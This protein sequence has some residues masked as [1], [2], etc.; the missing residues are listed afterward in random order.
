MSYLGTFWGD[1]GAYWTYPGGAWSR[2][3][4]AEKAKCKRRQEVKKQHLPNMTTG[5]GK[6]S[7]QALHSGRA[8]KRREVEKSTYPTCLPNRVHGRVMLASR[9]AQGEGKKRRKSAYPTWVP[10]RVHCHVRWSCPTPCQKKN[11]TYRTP[12]PDRV[13]GRVRRILLGFTFLD[14]LAFYFYVFFPF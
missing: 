5:S 7:G 4:K 9:L 2:A 14:F 8:K 10:D 1:F 6:L 12:L 13:L 11:C 3:R